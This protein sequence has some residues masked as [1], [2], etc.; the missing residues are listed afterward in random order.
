MPGNNIIYWN[1]QVLDCFSV[2][3]Q[4][5]SGNTKTSGR[6]S[7]VCVDR[8]VRTW[9]VNA[10]AVYIWGPVFTRP[11]KHS[12]VVL[13]EASGCWITSSFPAQVVPS[14]GCFISK[15]GFWISRMKVCCI[16]R[17][18]YIFPLLQGF[19]WG[20]K[21]S[22]ICVLPAHLRCKWEWLDLSPAFV[23][24]SLF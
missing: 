21:L 22:T 10:S 18:V 11:S 19:M 7:G 12:H 3:W 2:D 6:L 13:F 23:L 15:R 24:F 5:N 16:Y 9:S 8:R 14:S 17:G 1:Q 20:F 4:S